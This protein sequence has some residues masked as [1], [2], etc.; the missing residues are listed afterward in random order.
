[1]YLLVNDER[2]EPEGTYF[3]CGLWIKTGA[4]I[5]LKKGVENKFEGLQP[6]S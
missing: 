6:E 3:V 2:E 4:I 1:M 5:V